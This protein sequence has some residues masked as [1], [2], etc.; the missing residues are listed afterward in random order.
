M[1]V[2]SR[3]NSVVEGNHQNTAPTWW[4]VT[5]R[6]LREATIGGYLELVAEFEVAGNSAIHPHAHPTHEFYFVLAGTGEMVIGE[7]RRLVG[8][9]DL[10][11][12]PPNA[13]HSLHAS[14]TQMRCLVFAF[15]LPGAGEIDYITQ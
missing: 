14:G 10:I 13:V 3:K 9:G 2:R 11:R 7:E 12:I 15:A 5:P 6:E 4:L 8:P 1:D